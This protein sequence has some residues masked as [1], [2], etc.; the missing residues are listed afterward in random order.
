M[1]IRCMAAALQVIVLLLG[2][3][4]APEGLLRKVPHRIVGVWDLPKF[5][6]TP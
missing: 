3:E 2:V 4:C 5:P 1:Y 6:R